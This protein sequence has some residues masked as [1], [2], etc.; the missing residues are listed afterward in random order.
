M[1]LPLPNRGFKMAKKHV[2]IAFF[3]KTNFKRVWM[4]RRPDFLRVF[5]S[6][7]PSLTIQCKNRQIH[8]IVFSGKIQIIIQSSI[9]NYKKNN[10]FNFSKNIQLK[11]YYKLNFPEIFDY[12]N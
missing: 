11:Y 5:F 3:I 8:P 4:G 7:S 10:K 2:K 6:R 9:L 1:F 12:K